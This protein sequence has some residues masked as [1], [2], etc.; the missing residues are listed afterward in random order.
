VTKSIPN[1]IDTHVGGALARLRIEAG[2][3]CA[4]L[5]RE[6]RI[7]EQ[8]LEEIEAGRQRAPAALL[9]AVA[10]RFGVSTGAFYGELSADEARA[11]VDAARDP[12]TVQ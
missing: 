7:D 12:I 6:M 10:H 8:D 9:I 2:I 5:A 3:S 4:A 11:P 1:R